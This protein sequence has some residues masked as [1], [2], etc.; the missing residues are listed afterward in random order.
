[1]PAAAAVIAREQLR[2]LPDRMSRSEDNLTHLTG[3]IADSDLPIAP[4]TVP[5]G[6]RRG[7]YGAPFTILRPVADPAALLAACRAAGIPVRPVYPDWLSTP[8]LRRPDL[9]HRYWPH[10]RGRRWAPAQA[11][12]FPNYQR[13]R[14]QTLIL[15]IPD[16]PAPAYLEQVAAALAAVLPSA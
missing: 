14:A 16:V 6:S 4:I 11:Q 9:V 7:W 10:L 3:L 13:F 5:S 15:K 1:M 2:T 8:L 12:E